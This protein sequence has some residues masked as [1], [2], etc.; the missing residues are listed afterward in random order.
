MPKR[1]DIKS[2]C[3]IGA[4]IL[5]AAS[6]AFAETS[7]HSTTFKECKDTPYVSLSLDAFHRE[8]AG[9]NSAAGLEDF[10][11][12]IDLLI[13]DTP[14]CLVA[15]FPSLYSETQIAILRRFQEMVNSTECMEPN[16]PVDYDDFSW[17]H[18]SLRENKENCF[19]KNGKPFNWCA[20]YPPI[21]KTLESI[22][23]QHAQTH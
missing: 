20:K 17:C 3:I 5:L 6:H 2:I 15:A 22:N 7:P 12:L 13:K 16:P 1:T 4:L 21:L 19:D 18:P 23:T 14:E 11:G 8:V 9:A 10:D